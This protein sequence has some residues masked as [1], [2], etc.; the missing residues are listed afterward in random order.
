M[1]K[2]TLFHQPAWDGALS[3]TVCIGDSADASRIAEELA[4]HGL[5]P[6]QLMRSVVVSPNSRPR[7]ARKK[8]KYLFRDRADAGRA[9]SLLGAMPMQHVKPQVKKARPTMGKVRHELCSR[10][11]G[12]RS[13]PR[14]RV[15]WGGGLPP[16]RFRRRMVHIRAQNTVAPLSPAKPR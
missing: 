2:K 15:K 10:K 16:T 9:Q 12:Q 5:R 6:V 1:K 7:I 8:I 13:D 14:F 11:I 4:R 3:V